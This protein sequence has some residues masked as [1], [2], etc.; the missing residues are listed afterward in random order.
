M[1]EALF[2]HL[3]TDFRA[4]CGLLWTRR[5]DFTGPRRATVSDSRMS[6]IRPA[7]DIVFRF[8]MILGITRPPSC[9]MKMPHVGQSVTSGKTTQ[10]PD[11]PQTYP[12]RRKIAPVWTGRIPERFWG[13][14]ATTDSHR[15]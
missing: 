6:T 12:F 10:N 8:G 15:V 11:R 7:P 14:P 5:E 4:A 2:A 9:G 13:S 1:E 3:F